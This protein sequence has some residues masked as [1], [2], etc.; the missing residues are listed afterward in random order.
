[1]TIKGR[2]VRLEQIGATR[3][4]LFYFAASE[5][6]AIRAGLPLSRCLLTDDP[7]DDPAVPCTMTFEEIQE[8]LARDE[9]RP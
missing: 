8:E 3:R 6:V 2:V 7:N 4:P 5:S 1:M 9:A